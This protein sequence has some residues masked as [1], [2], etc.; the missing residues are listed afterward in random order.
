MTPKYE[1]IP[2][3]SRRDAASEAFRI[4][5]QALDLVRK[6]RPD[7][8]ASMAYALAKHPAP[9]R[10]HWHA[11][12]VLLEE[13][14]E[15]VWAILRRDWPNLREELCHVEVVCVRWREFS[16]DGSGRTEE[17]QARPSE[18]AEFSA[19]QEVSVSKCEGEDIYVRRQAD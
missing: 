17:V 14:A 10:S 13:V 6:H 18:D 19:R 16:Q 1:E 12:C 8:A 3:K 4:R 2:A 9:Y 7:L 11:A 15:V 5:C